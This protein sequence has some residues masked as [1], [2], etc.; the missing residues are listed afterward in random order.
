M[1]IKNPSPPLLTHRIPFLSTVNHEV[2]AKLQ[3][4]SI[5]NEYVLHTV[6]GCLLSNSL[7]YLEAKDKCSGI[8]FKTILQLFFSVTVE[9]RNKNW[10]VILASVDWPSFNNWRFRKSPWKSLSIKA[11][12]KCCGCWKV[13]MSSAAICSFPLSPNSLLSQSTLNITLNQEL[14]TQFC[15]WGMTT[16]L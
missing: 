14:H 9:S 7:C 16:L 2:R 3:P 13:R 15:Q 4:V 1:E 8:T 11:Q 5:F 10:A 12:R 6:V